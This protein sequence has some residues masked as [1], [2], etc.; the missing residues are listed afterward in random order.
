[1]EEGVTMNKEK[2]PTSGQAGRASG[3]SRF[4]TDPSKYSTNTIIDA[5]RKALIE[6]IGIAPDRIEADGK[7]H[8]FS[9]N[10]KKDDKSGRYV[11]HID[12]GIPAGYFQCYRQDIKRTWR[13]GRDL[14]P[15]LTAEER[16]AMRE[17]AEQTKAIKQRQ[18][19]KKQQEA[20]TR[21]VSIWRASGS[22]P[23]DY[24]YL[25]KKNIKPNGARIDGA[26]IINPMYDVSGRLWNLQ[27]IFSDG[28]KRF[29]TG[30]RKRGLFT[31]LGGV[32]L[33]TAARALV[34]EGWATGCTVSAIEPGTPVIVAFDAG[35]LAPVVGAVLGRF[36]GLKLV[37]V[38]DDDRKTERFKG[39]NVGIEK[40]LA[41]AAQYPAVS[42]VVPDF[43]INAPLELS[44]VNDL[45]S[46][47]NQ[48]QGG[49]TD[50][51]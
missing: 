10:G 29:L 45:V 23:F 39:K 4:T 30:G 47:R 7:I 44:D 15:D 35:N 18:E 32:K 41:V 43:P 46:W 24:P 37:I 8:R 26:S 17:Q 13:A 2:S 33:A 34:V 9:T 40:A 49:A 14:V 6:H 12:N 21:A 48:Q 16:Q 31:V 28:S 36:P 42:V 3:A 20:A 27:R 19:T 11:L 51:H 1:M 25:E 5:F 50:G 38:A 22:A